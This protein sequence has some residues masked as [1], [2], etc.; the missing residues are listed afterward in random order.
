MKKHT[1]KLTHQELLWILVGLRMNED[2]ARKKM[3][4]TPDI[5]V[6][7]GKLSDRV[8]TILEK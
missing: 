5:A 6:K 7:I 2:F 1:I 4:N 8:V 3:T